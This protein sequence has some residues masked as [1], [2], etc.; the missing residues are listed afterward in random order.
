MEAVTFVETLK[1]LKH[2]NPF[3]PFTIVLVNGDRYEVDHPDAF[4][5]RDG[6]AFYI[7]PGN[8]PVIFD[9]EGV[10]QVVGDLMEKPDT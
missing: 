5:A 3:R 4:V 9:H 2:R 7:A 1:T 8:I 6:M 10:S